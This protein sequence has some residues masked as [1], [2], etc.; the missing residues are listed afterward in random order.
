MSGRHQ[1]SRPSAGLK[2]AALPLGALLGVVVA[3]GA[4]VVA[5]RVW[6]PAGGCAG[7]LPLY[8]TTAP[9]VEP[10]VKAAADEFHQAKTAIGGKC[11]K[12]EVRPLNSAE[13]ATDIT[14]R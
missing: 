6:D 5:L 11:V 1:L 7:E 8:V 13:A 2:R 10:V 12:V 14:G 3:A 4:T 9:A